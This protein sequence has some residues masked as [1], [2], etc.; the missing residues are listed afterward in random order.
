MLL[1][2]QHI[3]VSCLTSLQV[4]DHLVGIVQRS[5][6]DPRLDLLI[7][8]EFEHLLNLTRRANGAAAKLDAVRNERE[9]VHRRKVAT[10]RSAAK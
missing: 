4:H 2:D 3:T 1:I 8:C 9:R 6:L 7:S 10:V 5:L